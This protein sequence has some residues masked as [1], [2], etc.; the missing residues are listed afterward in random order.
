MHKQEKLKTFYSIPEFHAAKKTVL[1]LGT[2]DGV[3]LGHQS[4]LAKLSKAS[5]EL[6]C[7]SLVLTFFPHPRMVLQQDSDIKLLNTIAEK[8]LLL[9][10]FGVDNL[11]V[12]PFDASFSQL[13]AEAF[14]SEVL[15]KQFNIAK[16]I[17]GYD[18]RFGKNR[19][20]TIEDLIVFGE[21]YSFEVEQ[22]SAQDVDEVSV[23]STKIRTALDN[24]DVQ[25]ANTF[26]GYDYFF[27]GKVVKGKQLGRTIGY[28]T[29]NIQI[30]EDYKLIPKIGV[31][32]VSSQIGGRTVFGMLNI[33]YNPTVNG[34]HKTIEVYFFDFEADLYDEEIT[35]AL[36]QR[37][38]D[39]Q[40]F[41]SVALLA[42]QLA[43]DKKA[44]LA[45]ISKHF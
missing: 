13:S 36:H 32:V 23:S 21:K 41:S 45:Y 27:S 9:Q 22:I 6:H 38:R 34:A 1:T 42:A 2:F 16:I 43:Q 15:V 39:E 24:G 4:I 37:I 8:S 30:F 26:L 28:P 19:S 25:T 33:G 14:V 17:I 12:H 7:E 11:V 20:A 10:R 5:K 44:A 29:A 40:K 35:I 3:H 18:H 31:Y